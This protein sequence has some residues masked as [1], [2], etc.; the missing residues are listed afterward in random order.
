MHTTLTGRSQESKLL[1]LIGYWL[2]EKQMIKWDEVVID[3]TN[4][5]LRI[6][7]TVEDT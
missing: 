5:F 2:Q 6:H 7:T 1:H 4:L 3:D